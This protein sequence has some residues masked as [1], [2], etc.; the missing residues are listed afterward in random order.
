MNSNCCRCA[1][2]SAF[3]AVGPWNGVPH[4]IMSNCHI[5]A[6][7]ADPHHLAAVIVIL[8]AVDAAGRS[9]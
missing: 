7:G 5:E 4:K 3:D 8:A 2:Q 9:S 6:P 1:R